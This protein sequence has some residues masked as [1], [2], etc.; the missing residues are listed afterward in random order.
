[1][2]Q[3]LT[4]LMQSYPV[5]RTSKFLYP[6]LP[7]SFLSQKF[8]YFII[9]ITNLELPKT[10]CK[11]NTAHITQSFQIG[12]SPFLLIFLHLSP[13]LLNALMQAEDLLKQTPVLQPAMFRSQGHHRFQLLCPQLLLLTF[14]QH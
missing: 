4:K 7:M 13:L 12:E 14:V 9:E 2:S 1:M 11:F 3:N 6:V 10:S 5:I 8:V